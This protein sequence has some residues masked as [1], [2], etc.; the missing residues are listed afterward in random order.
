MAFHCATFEEM[1][2]PLRGQM[3]F[4]SS[5]RNLIIIYLVGVRVIVGTPHNRVVIFCKLRESQCR[6]VSVEVCNSEC[7]EVEGRGQRT[8]DT[9][10][11]CVFF[12]FQLKLRLIWQ[13]LRLGV[14]LSLFKGPRQTDNG[15]CFPAAICRRNPNFFV[16]VRSLRGDGRKVNFHPVALHLERCPPTIV[17]ERLV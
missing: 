1:R 7:D 17:G 3:P 14:G 6:I 2:C 11:G 10:K 5:F 9:H 12:H 16:S 15:A 4:N 13:S 8:F